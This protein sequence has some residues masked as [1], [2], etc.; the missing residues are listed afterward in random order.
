MTTAPGPTVARRDVGQK[1]NRA[2]ALRVD[3]GP[4]A[5]ARGRAWCAYPLAAILSLGL[6]TVVL[7][8]WR[9]DL[10]IPLTY[11][12]E[13]LFNAVLVKGL[14]EQGWHLSNPALGAPAS[15]DLRDVPMSD[16]NLHFVLIR[17]L[18]LVTADYALVMNLFFVLTFPLTALSALYVFRRFGLAA[19]PALG[20]SLLYT[21]LPF[22]F[23]RGQHH[24]FL[25]AYYL[26]P[27]VVM[28]V[29]WI[30]TGS[31]SLVDERQGRWNWRRGRPQLVASAIVCVLIASSG[32]YYAF[33]ACFFLLVAGAVTALQRRTLRHL[34]LPLGL[35][36]LIIAVITA[37]FGPSLLHLYRHGDTPVVRR[38]PMEADT[39]ALR[40]SLL[41]MPATGHRLQ[42]VAQFKDAVNAQLPTNENHDASLGAIGSLGFLLLCGW[43]IRQ[44]LSGRGPDGEGADRLLR[45]L[46][47]LNLGAVLL[48]T[49]GG[50]GA[51]VALAI[52]PKIR[53]YTRISVYIAFFSLFAVVVGLDYLYRT[54]G[55]RRGRR[56]LFAIGLA[57]LIALGLLDQTSERW[58]PPYPKI[59][60]EYGSDARF[61]REL[62]A[63]LPPSA[64]IFQLPVV[65]YPEH[66][67]L[68]RMYDYDHARGYLHDQRHLRWSY[69]AMKGR[70]G[71]IWQKW[72]AAK[73][74]PELLETLAAAGFGGLY[75]NRDGYPDQGAKLSAEIGSGLG[76]P[77]LSSENGR[78]LFFDLRGYGEVWRARHTPAEWDA[79]R[80]AALH[81]LLMVW[82]NGCSDLEGST[83]QNFRWCSAAGAWRLTNSARRPQRVTLEMWFI[84]HAEGNLWIESPLLSARLRIG[85]APQRLARTI[86]IPPGQHTVSFGSDAPRVLA[87][88]ERRD[89]VFRVI[90]FSASPAE[91]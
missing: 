65:P 21:F 63:R 1:A 37:H 91:P 85:P 67:P 18:G 29:L 28:V 66:P 78:L 39:Y 69:G 79:K 76:Q 15:L 27:L 74:T 23:S 53:A 19:G 35:V 55:Q 89:L 43:L 33:F 22:H 10:R 14:L 60:A 58:I 62:Q 25:A 13:A 9:A 36:A 71:E 51:L 38:S 32:T 7:R 20:G 52:S 5:W 44:A 54:Q 3:G 24:L 16:N 72:V 70:A 12:A 80:E 50:F 73:R 42:G 56:A 82:Q 59:A 41:L 49:A 88:G 34:A 77:P 81:P 64:M 90:N 83:E 2:A 57:A 4:L 86:S 75:L 84:A 47:V 61:V 30:M 46:S 11:H 17:L 48:A 26:V 31:L 6:V 68:F 45:H 8:L 40:I 87:A